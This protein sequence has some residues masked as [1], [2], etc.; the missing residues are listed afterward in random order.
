MI[1]SAVENPS[2]FAAAAGKGTIC[3][4]LKLPNPARQ[5]CPRGGFPLGKRLLQYAPPTEHGHSEFQNRAQWR[6]GSGKTGD[7]ASGRVPNERVAD[8]QG[9]RSAAPS[10][11]VAAKQAHHLL[12]SR[13]LHLLIRPPAADCL[14]PTF[15]VC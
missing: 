9:Q 4:A 8:D 13:P 6:R 5:L 10:L 3:C 15:P 14:P 7:A 2:N 11:R 1:S 12:T